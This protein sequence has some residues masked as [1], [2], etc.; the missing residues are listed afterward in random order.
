MFGKP[1]LAGPSRCSFNLSHSEDD[2]V[3]LIAASGEIGVDV[4]VLRPMRDAL[5]L[6][7]R[8]FSA[9]ENAELRS[10]PE[11]ERDH[12]FLTAWTRKEACLKAL[13][14]GL[15]IAPQTFTASLRHEPATAVI[16]TSQG[17]A[18]V[19]VVSFCHDGRLLI[20]CAELWPS[21]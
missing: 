7:E 18:R 6:A 1:A 4:E 9:S 15:S 12:A 20:A 3:V 21:S 5:A 14:S 13:G 19:R 2:A 11:S 10:L 16:P 8:N 17:P